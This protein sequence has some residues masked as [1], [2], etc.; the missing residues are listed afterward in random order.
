MGWPLPNTATSTSTA[1][2]LALVTITSALV[3]SLALQKSAKAMP[4]IAI[5]MPNLPPQIHAGGFQNS[6]SQSLFTIHLP[7]KVMSTPA[8][9]M[10]IFVHGLADHC[11]RA[12]YIEMYQKLASAGV[13]VYSFDSHGH[14]RSEGEP[15]G[16]VEKFDHYVSDLLEYIQHCQQKYAEKGETSPPLLLLGHSMGALISVLAVLRLGSE[17]VGGLLLTG[18][19]LGVDMN[20][21]LHI[22]KM[23]APAIDKF[24][25]KSKI[26]DAVRPKD[27]SRNPEAVQAYIDD[28]L[29][30]KGKLI[31]RT[32]IQVDRAFDVAKERRGAITCPILMLH[33]TKDRCTSIKASRDFFR[34]VGSSKKRF[35]QLPGLFHEIFEEPEVGQFMP[36]IVGFV[37]SGGNEF[38]DIG[39]K[40][41]DGLIDVVFK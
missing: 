8:K 28:P 21:V 24:L 29:I 16:Y 41:D 14:G 37:S 26:V 5:E 4:T 38:V 27:M 2:T 22:Q 12:G 30:P 23:F 20:P 40:D 36:S 7:R 19:A 25:P 13:D 34:H 15:R 1:Q 9:S 10:L 6:R 17:N 31:A 35:L 3:I 11:C 39:G 32:A 33:G 18:P